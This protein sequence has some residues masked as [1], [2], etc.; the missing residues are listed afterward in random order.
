MSKDGH[1]EQPS[2][3]GDHASSENPYTT[4]V[5]VDDIQTPQRGRSVL[6]DTMKGLGLAI[7]VL[8]LIVVV[9][10]GLLVGCCT[11]AFG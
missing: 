8:L 7:A 11:M 2:E 4:P 9:G 5:V 6:V 3:E 1:V 10:Y